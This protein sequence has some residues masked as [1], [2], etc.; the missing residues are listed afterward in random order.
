[1]I[2]VTVD[3]HRYVGELIPCV[4]LCTTDLN[5]TTEECHLTAVALDNSR[6]YFASPTYNNSVLQQLN[7]LL[8]QQTILSR[9][10]SSFFLR[11]R[12]TILLIQPGVPQNGLIITQWSWAAM[13]ILEVAYAIHE[14]FIR[15]IRLIVY[16]RSRCEPDWNGV[17]KLCDAAT[18][19]TRR[20]N[21]FSS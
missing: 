14:I 17:L 6:T 20:R 11:W 4:S 1:M 13:R 18:I 5:C 2:G 19:Y 8:E 15:P 9:C 12:C 3:H 16:R 7:L 21:I 10:K